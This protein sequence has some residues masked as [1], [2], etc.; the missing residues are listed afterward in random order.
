MRWFFVRM[1]LLRVY[2]ILHD[3]V[4]LHARPW[5]PPQTPVSP[6]AS[7]LQGAQVTKARGAFQLAPHPS[8]TIAWSL[9]GYSA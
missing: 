4:I 1:W 6:V 2:A 8:M 5:G 3:C 9:H 7:Y